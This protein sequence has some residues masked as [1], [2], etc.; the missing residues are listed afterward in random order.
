ML[1]H[2]VEFLEFFKY[3]DINLFLLDLDFKCVYTDIPLLKKEMNIKEMFDIFDPEYHDSEMNNWLKFVYT[4]NPIT[5][6]A[7]CKLQQDSD[8]TLTEITIKTV[9]LKEKEYILYS[10]KKIDSYNTI[11]ENFLKNKKE[12]QEESYFLANMSHEI[13]T[14]L[15][16]IMGMLVLL[17]DTKLN[18]E[19]TDYLNILKECSTNLLSIINDI[20]DYSKLEHQGIQLDYNCEDFTKCID[21]IN[22]IIGLKIKEKGLTYTFNM[23]KN[24]KSKFKLDKTRFT[25]VLLNLLNNSVKFTKIG[26]ISLNISIIN[27]NPL[28]IRFD[29]SDTGCGISKDNFHKLFK[30]FSQI[31]TDGEN[32][33]AGLG[34]II[35][36]RLVGLMGGDIWLE[37]SEL[38]KGS[39]FSFVIPIEKC[40]TMEDIKYLDTNI[41]EYL[42]NQKIFILDDNRDN[43]IILSNILSKW[44]IIPHSFSSAVEAL[45][46][47][48]L[49]S[50]NTYTIGF[51][52]ENMPEMSG[53]EFVSKF[54]EQVGTNTDFIL[55]SSSDRQISILEPFKVRIMKP[56]NEEI[57]KKACLKLLNNISKLVIKKNIKPISI[58]IKNSIKILVAEDI[59]NNTIVINNFLKKL[60][61]QNVTFT[62]DGIECL[63]ELSKN[64][65]DIL[66]LDIKMP[67]LNGKEVLRDILDYYS[68]KITQYKLKN[69]KKPY[70]VAMTAYA[71]FNDKAKFLMM[72]FDNYISKPINFNILKDCLSQFLTIQ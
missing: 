52:D 34:L 67:K 16:G 20:L 43:R 59:E 68:G 32:E 53:K 5:S 4:K 24:L 18:S 14:P 1:T 66:L 51:I 8:Y 55:L 71:L 58:N 26:T 57:L 35:S 3:I 15:N 21:Y 63:E 7:N 27:H 45:H 22:S 46:M 12:L 11:I 41:L 44:G 60:D 49:Q 40:N 69:T 72:G 47:F 19:Q 30:S 62:K 2:D 9:L 25:Q 70:I 64:N 36:K 42:S 31:K 29:I 10:F 56:V 48:R 17:T 54:K 39:T 13:R 37:S 23:D 61:Y 38:N 6:I 28:R 65:Y 33:G 50:E